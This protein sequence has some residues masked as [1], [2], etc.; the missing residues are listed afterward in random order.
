MAER[1]FENEE[2]VM[3]PDLQTFGPIVHPDRLPN[4]TAAGPPTGP[5]RLPRS[6]RPPDG[7][8]SGQPDSPAGTA[9]GLARPCAGLEGG[10]G[11]RQRRQRDGRSPGPHR[12]SGVDRPLRRLH[13]SRCRCAT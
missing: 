5:N 2:E 10:S 4:C 1:T 8:I 11:V 13:R 6:W 3:E 9:D 7:H 12:C